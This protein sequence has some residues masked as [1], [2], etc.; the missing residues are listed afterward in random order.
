MDKVNILLEIVPPEEHTEFNFFVTSTGILLQNIDTMTTMSIWSVFQEL[1]FAA[2]S[3]RNERKSAFD[4]F[5]LAAQDALDDKA[6]V[7]EFLSAFSSDKTKDV[8]YAL[9]TR[10]WHHGAVYDK[11]TQDGLGYFGYFCTF[12]FHFFNM[13]HGPK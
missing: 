1:K 4:I 9:K 5:C 13:Q 7:D 3:L 11:T 6:R 12:L 2:L 8:L 10:D